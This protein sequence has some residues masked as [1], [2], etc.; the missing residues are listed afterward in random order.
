MIYYILGGGAVILWLMYS[1][2]KRGSRE[3]NDINQALV[4]IISY[5]ILLFPLLRYVYKAYFI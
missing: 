2:Y 5:G 4:T 3:I 1:R